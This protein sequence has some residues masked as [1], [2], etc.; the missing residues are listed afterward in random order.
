MKER[1]YPYI[2]IVLHLEFL[3][4]VFLFLLWLLPKAA[5]RQTY[6][7]CEKDAAPSLFWGGSP[8][9]Q[10]GCR[11]NVTSSSKAPHWSN[12]CKCTFLVDHFVTR[13]LSEYYKPCV[14]VSDQ[15]SYARICYSN[16]TFWIVFD[17]SKVPEEIHPLHCYNTG[18][19]S[20]WMP[21]NTLSLS[22]SHTHLHSSIFLYLCVS[23]C[24]LS[25]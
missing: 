16:W 14:L 12:K 6:A 22:Y 21:V 13:T 2:T 3:F 15:H 24:F 8:A 5:F 25:S 11:C 17:V 7:L 18:L 9:T 23:L 10:Y 4:L 20:V 1:R 19:F